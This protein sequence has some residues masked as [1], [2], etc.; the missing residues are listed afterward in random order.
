MDDNRIPYDGKGREGAL[1]SAQIDR[2]EA[3]TYD[4]A[5]PRRESA[6]ASAARWERQ[7]RA[8]SAG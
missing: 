4:R 2:E 1:A 6:L 7:A 3:D 8:R 5:D